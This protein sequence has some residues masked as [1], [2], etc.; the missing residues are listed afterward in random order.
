ML[1]NLRGILPTDLGGVYGSIV[2]VI[3]KCLGLILDIPLAAAPAA[4][5]VSGVDIRSSI[6]VT[7]LIL[8]SAAPTGFNTGATTSP[9]LSFIVYVI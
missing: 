7:S 3:P 4:T 9:V 8:P 1:I 6:C 2:C 5:K